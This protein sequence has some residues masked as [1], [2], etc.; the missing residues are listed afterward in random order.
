MK[1]IVSTSALAAT[2]IISFGC[3]PLP[4][5]IVTPQGQ[6]AFVADQVLQRVEELENAAMAAYRSGDIPRNQA[7]AVVRA[8]IEMAELTDAAREGWQAVVMKAWQDAK[9]GIPALRTGR[10]AA[11]AAALDAVFFGPGGQP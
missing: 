6:R 3:A 9:A 8:T 4:P 5:T 10:L 7:R 2:L 1:Q 11:Y